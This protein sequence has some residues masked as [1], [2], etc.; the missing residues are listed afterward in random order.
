MDYLGLD[1]DM[2]YLVANTNKYS[3]IEIELKLGLF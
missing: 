1:I 3:L 2:D